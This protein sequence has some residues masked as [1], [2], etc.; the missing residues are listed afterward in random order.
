MKP[1]HLDRFDLN[2]LVVLN[3]VYVERSVT[4]A[5]AS[6]NLTQSAVSHA[7]RR[8]R[9]SVRDRLFERHGTALVPTPLMK[10][11]AQPLN[12]SLR[13]LEQVVNSGNH[14]EPSAAARCFVVGMDERLELFALP[15]FIERMVKIAPNLDLASVH[16]DPREV[17]ALLANGAMDVV[18]GAETF[19]N[20]SLKRMK[21]A[22]DH[23]I[24][25]ARSGHPLVSRQRISLR[26]YQAAEHIAVSGPSRQP[27]EDDLV[28]SRSGLAR[29][30]RIR[31]RRY[32]AAMDIVA[33]TDML[34]TLPLKY[35][36]VINLG[37]GHDL[38]PLPIKMAPMEFF[39]HWHTSTTRDSAGR[40]L[41]DELARSFQSDP[42]GIGTA[43]FD[44]MRKVVAG[45]IGR[46]SAANPSITKN[47]E[48]A[49]PDRHCQTAPSG[50]KTKLPAR[51][52]K[53]R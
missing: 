14:F 16:F 25:A 42:A 40:W 41:R 39:L 46:G 29:R 15:S 22:Q 20:P 28:L 2:L 21:V 19:D 48:P 10:S 43:S 12:D 24:V 6:L 52:S 51:A 7:L 32:V 11:L 23:L 38:L 45:Q 3:R 5:A 44:A 50:T 33:R 1:I 9:E 30:I 53:A 47:V 27:T 17:A 31:V 8:L 35:A 49:R 13:S 34:L 37:Y 4:R 36:Q 18:V 26:S